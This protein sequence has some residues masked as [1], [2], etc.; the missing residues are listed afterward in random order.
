MSADPLPDP[1]PGQEVASQAVNYG[2]VGGSGAR[3]CP[4][5]GQ[6]VRRPRAKW[7]RESCRVR[8]WQRT[9]ARARERELEELR[10]FKAKVLEAMNG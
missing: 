6:E 2:T 8:A 10:A 4:G 9:R 7:C 1:A 3:S 5:C